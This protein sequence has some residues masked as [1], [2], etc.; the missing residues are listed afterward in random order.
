[1]LVT[2]SVSEFLAVRRVKLAAYSQEVYARVLDGFI[3]H[4]AQCGVTETEQL[5]PMVVARWVTAQQARGLS[6]K[7]V[8]TYFKVVHAWL[9]WLVREELAPARV[10]HVDAPRLEK[11]IPPTFGP[12]QIRLLARAARKSDG[13]GTQARDVALVWLLAD[14]G[15]RASEVGSLTL[16]NLHLAEGYASVRGKG[17][18]YREVGPLSATTVRA[19]RAWLRARDRYHPSVT[20]VFVTRGGKAMNRNTLD[21]LLRRLRD[22]AGLD[23]VQVG[24]HKFRHSWARAQALA[25]ADVLS[26]SRLAGHSSIAIT[27]TY[28]GTFGSAD[29][30]RM[31]GSVVDRL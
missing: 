15:L 2:E 30:R 25:G 13:S 29:A 24:A 17:G 19:L 12:D 14:T 28:L 10:L 27:Q 21:A 5:T 23:G 3:A 6:P 16:E 11:K 7:S 18:R 31:V 22:K 8:S 4:G 26:I 1:M 9:V 20:T